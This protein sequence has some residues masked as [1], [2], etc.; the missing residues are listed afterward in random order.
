MAA[1]LAGELASDRAAVPAAA[2]VEAS[3][4]VLFAVD[5]PRSLAAFDP[6]DHPVVLAVAVRQVA[7]P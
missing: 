6:R 3:E 7:D 2:P 4:A 5:F 1:H